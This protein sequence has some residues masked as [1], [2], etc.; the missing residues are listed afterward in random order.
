MKEQTFVLYDAGDKSAGLSSSSSKIRII[1]DDNDF[2]GKGEME[3]LVQTLAGFYD[4]QCFLKEEWDKIRQEDA[5]ADDYSYKMWLEEK[6]IEEFGDRG[7]EFSK[8]YL[9]L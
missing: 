4:C 9:K 6:L 8:Q 2:P 5:Q 3:D 1:F 7:L